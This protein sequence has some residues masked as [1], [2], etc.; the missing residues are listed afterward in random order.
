MVS[1]CFSKEEGAGSSPQEDI[2]GSV[3]DPQHREVKL[4]S[5]RCGRKSSVDPNSGGLIM[6]LPFI[7]S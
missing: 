4:G 1:S 2:I 3:I 5:W 7:L 6:N